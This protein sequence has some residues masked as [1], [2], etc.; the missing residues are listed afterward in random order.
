[1]TCPD[2]SLAE[3]DPGWPGLDSACPQCEIRTFASSPDRLVE[4]WL[5]DVQS[6]EGRPVA[7]EKGR[8]VRAERE[9][10]AAMKDGA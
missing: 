9:R 7:L 3:T 8:K 5:K 1:M 6:K 2:C 4:S 10:A